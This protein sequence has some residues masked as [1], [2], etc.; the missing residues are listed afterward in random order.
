VST[1]VV[2]LLSPSA[3]LP[4]APD[5]SRPRWQVWRSP[6][7]QPAWSRPALL[8]MAAVAACL[9]GRNISQAGLSPFYSVAV[10]SMS[11]SWKAFF[12]GALDPK[13]T[14]TIDKLAGSF[15]P[16]A[17]SARI[18]GY[19]PWSLA[20]PQVI[21]GTIAT[22]V[23]YRVV[24]RWAGAVPGLVA[25]AIFALTPIAASM[26][27]HSM[28][29]GALTMCLVLA[30]DS[31][32][33]AVMDARLR[34]LIW[35]GV[36]VGLGFQA[37]MLQ[38]W[39]VVPALALGYLVAAP[40]RLRRRLG[41]LAVAGVVMLAVSLSWIALYT[42]T[43]AADRPWVDGSTSNSAFAMVFGYNGLERFGIKVPGAVESGPGVTAG[44]GGAGGAARF[45]RG[46]GLGNGFAEDR[47]GTGARG[48]PGAGG[49]ISGTGIPGGGTAGGSTSGS[50][51]ASAAAPG[52]GTAGTGAGGGLAGAQPGAGGAAPGG[53]GGRGAGGRGGFGNGWTKLLGTT[54]GTQVG[55]LYPLAVLALVFGL[56]L[57]RRARRTDQVRAGFVMWGAW[58][59]TF[60]LIFSDMSTIPHTAYVASLAPPLAALSA[61]GIVMFWRA[62]R[63][64]GWQAWLLPVAVAAE[65][66]WAW[67]LWRDYPDFLPWARTAALVVGIVA[68]VAL[69]TVLLVRQ[70]RASW[71]PGRRI[72]TRVVTVGLAAAV[73][74]MLAAPATWAA[75][76]LDVKYG[77]SSLNAGAGP[78]DGG[79]GGFGGGN[80]RRTSAAAR[81]AEALI[82]DLPAGL[83]QRAGG[84]GGFGGLA[85][86]SSTTLSSSERAIYD[87]V[88]AHRDG[89]SYLMAVSSW[90]TASPYIVATGQEVMPMGGFS[91]TV[92]EPSLAKVKQLVSSGQLRFFLLDGAG[93]PTPATS[94][95]GAGT[96]TGTGTRAAGGFGGR[97]AGNATVQA[98]TSWVQSSCTQVPAQDYAASSASTG[99]SSG[100]GG[101]G[102]FGG[103]AFGGGGGGTLYR[104]GA[105]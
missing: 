12:Y 66:A 92:P 23:M 58:L 35:A 90:S 71:L 41:H 11:V 81:D 75:S 63:V 97:G 37:K 103:G 68:V 67:Y 56:V 83:T 2:D 70:L 15:L 36:W 59:L 22:L 78:V 73:V 72:W 93:A 65:L 64:G 19:H 86:S 9:F 38:A 42:F 69:V 77:G 33:R 39:M 20:L 43:P 89:A 7:G 87:Y 88:S 53:F 105:A 98:V 62:F 74:A 30:A 8:A 3:P 46:G 55:W 79:F 49:A 16:Q 102:A 4:D 99:A 50:A 57:T 25:A 1:A 44:G 85:G 32:Q 100:S 91:G 96:G 29:D 21:E 17:L 82:D 94:P 51:T 104:C 6:A 26:F 101:A 84:A 28:E 76:V 5:R 61:A 18:F 54:Y 47:F 13:A 34:S 27:G 10:K 24:R 52:G 95:A 31:Y 14:I 40:A 80:A 48:E 45:E 60:G